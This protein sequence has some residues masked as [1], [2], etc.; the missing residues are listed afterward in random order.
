[1]GPSVYAILL[2]IYLLAFP[3][4]SG[5]ENSDSA[6]AIGETDRENAVAHAS[7]A[8]ETRLVRTV[9]H[10]LRNY[11]FRD[12]KRVLCKRKRDAV[13]LAVLPVLLCIPFEARIRHGD[14]LSR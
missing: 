13:L 5:A 1:M 8:E 11:T 14:K 10:V 9:R 7:N 12:G 6:F 2:L 4:V 3:P